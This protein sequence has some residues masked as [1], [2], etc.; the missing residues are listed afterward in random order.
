MVEVLSL[1]SDSGRASMNFEGRLGDEGAMLTCVWI[2]DLWFS[3]RRNMPD[4]IYE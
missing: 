4:L 2:V 3:M 1:S